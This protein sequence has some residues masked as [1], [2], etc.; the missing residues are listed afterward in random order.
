M[1]NIIEE[2]RNTAR[3]QLYKRIIW[4]LVII[5]IY[6]LGRNISLIEVVP[7]EIENS[8]FSLLKIASSAT[9]GNIN[10][11][12]LF[13]LGLGPW[14][15]AM[16][17]WRVIT[18]NKNWKLDKL[19]KKTADKIQMNLTLV[20][21]FIQALGIV[22]VYDLNDSYLKIGDYKWPTMFMLC[23]ILTAGAFFLVWLSFRNT[24]LGLGNS[25]VIIMVGM[26]ISWPAE[27]LNFFLVGINNLDNATLIVIWFL[28]G[29]LFILMITTI[30]T[31]TAEYRVPVNR[32]MLIN[33]RQKSYIP[34][35]LNPAGGMPIMYA[36][37]LMA[38]FQYISLALKYFFPT[39]N[40]VIWFG[41]N[42]GLDSF[43][44]VC[45]YIFILYSLTIGFAFINVTPDKLAENMQKSGDYIDNVRP[46]KDTEIYLSK[47]VSRLAKIGAAYIIIFTGLPMF[48]GVYVENIRDFLTIPGSAF[49]IVGMT[50]MT[51]DQVNELL[52]RTKY[53]DIL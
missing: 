25:V 40:G 38:L 34:I 53:T 21:G 26:M 4:T 52:I 30:I 17:I 18:M 20:I 32:I 2:V 24:D 22:S 45:I 29:L 12:T 39:N 8:S 5:T 1:T 36:F 35:K 11:L 23:L 3:K 6:I 31:E 14:M 47:I 43:L 44:G 28:V 7:K 9:G 42:I 48:L 19:P 51:I 27:I 37:T 33:K 10:N 15:S 49:I 50:V 46:G 13:S 41:K 16:I